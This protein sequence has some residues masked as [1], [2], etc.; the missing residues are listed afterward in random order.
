MDNRNAVVLGM[1]DLSAVFDTINHEI[2]LERL[3]I[4]HGPD[5]TVIKW[6][7]SYLRR[8]VTIDNLISEPIAVEEGGIQG[9]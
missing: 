5:A 3:T 4:S 8:R 1:L 6:F 2:V 9:S 7:E